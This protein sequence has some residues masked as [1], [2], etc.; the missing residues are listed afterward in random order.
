MHLRGKNVTE[1]NNVEISTF[2]LFVY[3]IWKLISD[4]FVYFHAF[5]ILALIICLVKLEMWEYCTKYQGVG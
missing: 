5:D 1:H 2:I 3:V 4:N